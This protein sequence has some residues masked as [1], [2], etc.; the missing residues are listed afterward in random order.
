MGRYVV[1]GPT[2]EPRKWFI[3]QLILCYS[4]HLL[5]PTYLPTYLL[6][7]TTYILYN[8]SE[9][10]LKKKRSPLHFLSS[11]DLFLLRI[12]VKVCFNILFIAAR[13]GKKNLGK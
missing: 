8:K 2:N 10:F 4:L 3:S 11:D 9:I 1:L 5:P 7:P 13:P 12:S 6:V